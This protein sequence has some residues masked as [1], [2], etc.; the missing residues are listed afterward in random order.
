MLPPIYVTDGRC[1]GRQKINGFT[2]TTAAVNLHYAAKFVQ[3][4]FVIKLNCMTKHSNVVS[5][6]FKCEKNEA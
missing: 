5:L 2:T 1:H 3:N 6:H 4:L